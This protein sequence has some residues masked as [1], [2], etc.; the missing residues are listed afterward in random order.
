[1]GVLSYKLFE[2]SGNCDLIKPKNIDLL[3]EAEE[4]ATLTRM[5]RN[6]R[7]QR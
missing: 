2:Q 3:P 5:S 1:M 6:Q 7:S 4:T